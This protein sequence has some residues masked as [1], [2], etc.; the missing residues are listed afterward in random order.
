MPTIQINKHTYHP[1]AD[2]LT[3]RELKALAK[4]DGVEGDYE[5]FLVHTPGT[6]KPGDEQIR[7]DQTIQLQNGMRFRAVPAGNR[8]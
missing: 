7:D 4:N 3:G 8:G 2:A 1:D 6:G 5:L